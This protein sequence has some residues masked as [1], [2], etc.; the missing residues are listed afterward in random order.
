MKRLAPVVAAAALVLTGC[1]GN[2]VGSDGPQPG[3]AAEVDGE[4][5]TVDQVDEMIAEYC[6]LWNDFED[7]TPIAKSTLRS[8]LVRS[9]VHS[10]GVE[11][12][13]EEGDI[14]V[15]GRTEQELESYWS[16]LGELD[17][18]NREPLGT[19]TRVE[20]L[21][22]DPLL[23]L[24]T[25]RIAETSDT[26]PSGEEAQAAG[27]EVVTE[28]LAEH[29]VTVNPAFGSLE[30]G[31]LVIGGDELSVAVSGF[32]TTAAE[33]N[34]EAEHLNELPAVQR[35]GPEADPQPVAPAVPVE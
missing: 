33:L 20:D 19:I 18:D 1:S 16:Q 7:A 25:E 3:I 2:V 21:L 15:Q 28:W 35:C 10:V 27:L 29:D 22:G 12:L 32:A 14:P 9:W 24:G 8:L 5:L 30:D 6:T 13:A 4:V 23:A 11:R 31:E 26:P 17:D 34:P